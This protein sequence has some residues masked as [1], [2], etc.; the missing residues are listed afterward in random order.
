MSRP[1]KPRKSIEESL[2]LLLIERGFTNC[3]CEVK[4]LCGKILAMCSCDDAEKS[5]PVL[6]EKLE[7]EPK[8]RRSRK[9]QA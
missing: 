2:I 5:G 3:E 8:S 4:S 1:I 7:T 9:S 6:E